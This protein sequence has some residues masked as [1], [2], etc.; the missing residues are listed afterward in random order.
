MPAIVPGRAGTLAAGPRG[1]TARRPPLAANTGIV[2]LVGVPRHRASRYRPAAVRAAVY[3]WL[4]EIPFR[5]G[6]RVLAVVAAIIAVSKDLDRLDPR[7]LGNALAN[8][9]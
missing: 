5:T 3:A 8:M 2:L 6:V 9:A 7:W 1:I 4:E